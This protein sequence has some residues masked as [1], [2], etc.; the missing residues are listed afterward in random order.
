MKRLGIVSKLTLWYALSM[1][2]IVSLMLIFLMYIGK[3][4][5]TDSIQKR[6]MDTVHTVAKEIEYEDKISDEDDIYIVYGNGY[7][8]ID[9]DSLKGKD[10]IFIALYDKERGMLYGD[11]PAGLQSD[12][13]KQLQQIRYNGV[14]YYIYDMMLNEIGLENIWIRGISRP[15]E[16]FRDISKISLMALY[17]FPLLVLTSVL[18]GYIMAKGALRPIENIRETALNIG[19]DLDLKR[20]IDIGEGDDE[21]HK[22]ARV[23]N[24]M[25]D[26]LHESFEKEKRF[27][28]DAS[29]ELRTPMAVI[30]AQCDYL[31]SVKLQNSPDIAEYVE[32]IEVIHRQAGR[33]NKIIKNLLD[34]TRL[35]N[36]A[37]NKEI[38]DL[39]ALIIGICKDLKLLN[40]NDINLSEDVED[41]VYIHGNRDLLY[42]M[43]INIIN[44]AYV[45]GKE[46][47]SISVSLF[48]DEKNIKV[49]IKDNGIGISKEKL[50][51]IFERFYRA[52]SSHT[53][54][55]TGLGLSMAMEI[56]KWHG[57]NI[58][59]ESE[60]DIGSTFVV[61]LPKIKA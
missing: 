50:V 32:G 22:L 44:N 37:Y 15:M 10:G 7:I 24:D 47:G 59:A 61:I 8:E 17:T 20:H 6:L 45:Y 54:K 2:I 41:N 28:S 31:N 57:G 43:F 18:M 39:S 19:S 36:N 42:R 33:M 9:E 30:T 48:T 3:K 56:A 49:I 40:I 12:F 55:G 51:H 35:G 34:F 27:A 26:R 52:D 1:V 23:F 53:G 14:D 60:E 5:T 58:I 25:F 29:H 4:I 16:S 13:S 21:L 38:V 11:L 46:K